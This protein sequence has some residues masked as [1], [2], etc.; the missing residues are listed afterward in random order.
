MQGSGKTPAGTFRLPWAFGMPKQ[1]DGWDPSYRKVRNGD[2]WVLD[3]ESNHY[4]RYRNKEQG[5][6]RWWLD[7][8]HPDASERLKDYPDQYEWA[9]VTSFNRSQV[10]APRRGDLPP[11]QRQRRDRRLRQRAALV[12]AQAD[13]PARPGPQAVDRDR[14]LTCRGRPGRGRRPHP[15]LS[16]LDKVLY[17]QTG[18]TKG[19]VL[20]Y[21]AQV[22]PVM[23]PHLRTGP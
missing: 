11:R 8:S 10:T 23:L 9:V 18:T 12:H 17:P 4:N 3:N 5:G 21:Y 15:R 6:F 22:A 1:H 2:Y 13:V 19:E 16:D 14:E 7:A 20:N